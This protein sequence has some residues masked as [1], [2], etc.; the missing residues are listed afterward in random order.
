MLLVL[1]LAPRG[2]SLATLV[3]P[4][5]QRPTFPNSNSTRNW[6]DEE[7]LSGYATTKSLFINLGGEI[8]SHPS[9]IILL[10]DYI[11]DNIGLK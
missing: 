6:V 10:Q 3:L 7:L 4:S 2:F 9:P 11:K 1:P 8:V 5:P